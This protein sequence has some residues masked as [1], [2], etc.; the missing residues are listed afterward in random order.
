MFA[1]STY[2]ESMQTTR[3]EAIMFTDIVGY[4]ALMAKDEHKALGILHRHRDIL[5]PLISEFNGEWLKEMGDGSG[6]WSCFRAYAGQWRALWRF[7]K[8]LILTT[9]QLIHDSGSN[10]ELEY[11]SG[12]CG[13]Q[14]TAYSGRESMLPLACSHFRCRGESASPKTFS[15]RSSAR[16]INRS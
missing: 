13:T 2:D 1:R 14:T 12:K 5:K 9:R 8:Q 10:C 6:C 3:L 15:V 7:R 4:T 11:I 16:S